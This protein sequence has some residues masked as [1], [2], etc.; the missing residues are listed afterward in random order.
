MA[1][2]RKQIEAYKIKVKPLIEKIRDAPEKDYVHDITVFGD[3]SESYINALKTAHKVRQKQM[4]EGIIGQTIIGNF[5]GW[6]DLGHAPGSGL[7]CLKKD[8]SIIIEVK[9]RYN[10]CNADSK[11]SVLDKL[12]EYKKH[13][14]QTRCIWG[15]VNPT[16]KTKKLS[17]T[18]KYKGLELEKLQGRDLFELVFT[19]DNKNYANEI[20]T[21]VKHIL[22][23]TE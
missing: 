3:N 4:K 20:I 17:A 8:N 10:T 21:F 14:P 15:I 19:L 1:N 6:K 2:R 12:W 13:N 7:D 11:K 9:N 23:N 22:I 16:S 18:F 5:C